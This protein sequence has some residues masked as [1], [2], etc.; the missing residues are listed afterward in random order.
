M[1]TVRLKM[2]DREDVA[3]DEPLPNLIGRILESVSFVRDYIQLDFG[4]VGMTVTKLPIVEQGSR[5][6]RPGEKGYRDELCNRIGKS[7][8]EALVRNKEE[9]RISF[10]DEAS[11]RVFIGPTGLSVG[12]NVILYEDGKATCVW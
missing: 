6:L 8:R 9:I 7:V 12:E 1:R 3:S 2:I 4:S 5:T 11:V 10:E